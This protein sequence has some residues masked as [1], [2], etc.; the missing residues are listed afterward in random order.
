MY[1]FSEDLKLFP[2]VQKVSI[3][4]SLAVSKFKIRRG[5]SR[6][7]RTEKPLL[8]TV[9]LIMLLLVPGS[10]AN[11]CMGTALRSFN[12]HHMLFHVKTSL[13]KN[14]IHSKCNLIYFN[15]LFYQH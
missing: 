6:A 7:A 5:L 15:T 10:A 1:D 8:Y 11:F 12:S 13:E 2:I 9:K 14:K 3:I 4:A